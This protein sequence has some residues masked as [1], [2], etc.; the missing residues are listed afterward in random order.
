MARFPIPMAHVGMTHPTFRR[1]VK[2]ARVYCSWELAPAD[3]LEL[4]LNNGLLQSAG[5][6]SKLPT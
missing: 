2:R 6:L 5:Q 3:R 4:G 1:S